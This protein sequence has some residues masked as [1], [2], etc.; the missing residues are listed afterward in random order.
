MDVQWR[1][2][3]GAFADT[4]VDLVRGADKI[5]LSAIDAI[6]GTSANDGFAFIGTEAFHNIAGELRYQQDASELR[7]QGDL[8]GNGV[9]DFEIFIRDNTILTSTDFIL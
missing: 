2:W 5:D 9:A 3:N 4:I 6:A 1:C 7:I 8:D